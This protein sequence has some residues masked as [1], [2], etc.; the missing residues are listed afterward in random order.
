MAW[1]CYQLSSSRLSCMIPTQMHLRVLVAT[2]LL[3]VKYTNSPCEKAKGPTNLRFLAL[4]NSSIASC[5]LWFFCGLTDASH[6][7][8]RNVFTTC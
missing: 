7:A 3:V 8:C 1:C 4:Y 2:L 5:I 6:S